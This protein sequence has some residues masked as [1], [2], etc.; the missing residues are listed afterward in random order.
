M[1]ELDYASGD[2][3]RGLRASEVPDGDLF[4]DFEV[5]VKPLSG[6]D[7]IRILPTKPLDP[8]KRYV[9]A[10]TKEILDS[11]GEPIVSSPAYTELKSDLVLGPSVDAVR[12]LIQNFW[13]P[14][15]KSA[16]SGLRSN[17]GGAEIEL[18]NIA[19]AY[20]FTTS[21]DKKSFS[22]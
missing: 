11:N 8:Y 20:S 2:P 22:T 14:T 1:I 17:F 3:L 16:I 5:E 6:T 10:L 21:N 12:N 4:F 15:A 7:Y 13:E 9:V 18:E 19:L